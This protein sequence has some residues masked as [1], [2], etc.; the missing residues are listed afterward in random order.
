MYALPNLSSHNAFACKPWEFQPDIPDNATTNKD[1]FVEWCQK[2]TTKHCHFSACE[3]MDALRRVAADNPVVQLHGFVADFDAVIPV[4]S[5]KALVEKSPVEY[6]PNW[7]A[8]TF[9]GGARLVW[10]FQHPVL[11][12]GFDLAKAFHQIAMKKLKLTKFLPGL[13][14]EAFVDTSKYYERGRMWIPLSGGKIPDAMLYNW[15]LEAG[16]KCKWVSND[17]IRIPMDRLYAEVKKCFPGK[18]NGPFAEGARGVR[19][20]DPAADNTTA[21]VVRES[22]MQCFTGTRP[23]ISWKEIFGPKFVEEYEA[24]SVGRIIEGFFFDGKDYWAKSSTGVWEDINK[25]D[26]RL[27]MKVKHGMSAAISKGTSYSEVDR[28]L[29]AIQTNKRI[30][31][32]LPFVHF[33]DGLFKAPDGHLYLNTA[34]AIPVKPVDAP[35]TEWGKDFPWMASFLNGFFTTEKQLPFFLAWWKYFYENALKQTPQAGQAIFLIGP[36]GVGKTLMSSG[37]VGPSVGGCADASQ[38]L[39]GEEN[40]TSHILHAPVMAVDDTCPAANQV[41]HIR[42][43]SMIKKVVANRLILYNQKFHDAGHVTWLGR[44]IVTGNDDPE[45]IRLLPNV[46]I[47]L[48]DKVSFFHCA[49]RKFPFPPSDQIQSILRKELPSFCRWLLDWK[50]PDECVGLA[51]FGVKEFHDPWLMTGAIHASGCFLFLEALE[52]FLNEW[53]T[54]TKKSVWSGTATTLL[55]DLS[56]SIRLGHLVSRYNTS[57]I[58]AWLGQ[59]QSK[60]VGMNSRRE[61]VGRK[62]YIPVNLRASSLMYEEEDKKAEL[63]ELKR[64]SE[65]MQE[66]GLLPEI[67]PA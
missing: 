9:S 42:Y 27:H 29:H 44:I 12:R 63:R 59:L 7:G 19:F 28:V 39:M 1:I 18:W 23:F 15:L 66:K 35:V 22:G 38:F 41:N 45:S 10:E 60:G 67:N 58:S 51:R 53:K 30:T 20:W 4:E 48:T 36:T 57:M 50:I 56:Q 32:A 11:V 13:D 16:N 6:V 65:L 25:E 14:I 31:A 5:I 54:A 26:L 40:F 43:S 37:L 62:W 49:F 46:D 17:S 47:S 33:P 52:E 34:R 61:S 64:K 3:G 24:D 8:Q 2:P 55:L 21:A